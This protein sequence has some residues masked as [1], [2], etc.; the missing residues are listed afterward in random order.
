MQSVVQAPAG[1]ARDER[2]NSSESNSTET[3]AIRR[4]KGKFGAGEAINTTYEML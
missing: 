2:S 3:P 1:Q 4:E